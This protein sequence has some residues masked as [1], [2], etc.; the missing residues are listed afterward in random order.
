MKVKPSLSKRCKD[1]QFVRR[2]GWLYVICK[3]NKRH[4]QRQG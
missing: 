3:V 2:R 4:K 1:C